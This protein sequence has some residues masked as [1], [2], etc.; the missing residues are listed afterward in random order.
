MEKA[1]RL[2]EVEGILAGMERLAEVADDILE[3][4]ED[5]QIVTSGWSVHIPMLGLDLHEGIFCRYDGQEKAY[6]PDYAV[7]VLKEEGQEEWIYYGQDGFVETV[8][9]YLHGKMEPGQLE[10]LFCFICMPDGGPQTEG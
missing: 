10:R 3:S 6:L 2:G 5:C 4:D 8:A 7:T 1:Y 9:G